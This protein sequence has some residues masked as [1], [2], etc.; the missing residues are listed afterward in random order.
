VNINFLA[1]YWDEKRS[2]LE[3]IL[4]CLCAWR[5]RRQKSFD[6][7]R[8]GFR[9]FVHVFVGFCGFISVTVE[10]DRENSSRILFDQSDL[11]M[12]MGL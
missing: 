6:Y 12:K 5:R 1:V 3:A 7:R 8:F 9:V 4:G 11:P 10:Y 2:L